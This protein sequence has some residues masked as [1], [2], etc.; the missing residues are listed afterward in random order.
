[1]AIKLELPEIPGYPKSKVIHSPTVAS[2]GP[3]G[4]LDISK[5]EI[6]RTVS[7]NPRRLPDSRPRR[8]SEKRGSGQDTSQLPVNSSNRAKVTAPP[9]EPSADEGPAA[10]LQGLMTKFM[11]LKENGSKAEAFK[12]LQRSFSL[13]WPSHWS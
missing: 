13:N 12:A 5:R 8:S 6:D 4:G 2:V 10:V 7:I 11:Y 9:P 1:M 3:D